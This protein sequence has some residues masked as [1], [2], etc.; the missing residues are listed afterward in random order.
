MK[1]K[2][3]LE[4][5]SLN[6][7]ST[8][9]EAVKLTGVFTNTGEVGVNGTPR[10]DISKDGKL[11]ATANSDPLLVLPRQTAN[12]VAYFAPASAG[13]YDID[14]HVAYANKQ[15][16]DKATILNVQDSGTNT[17]LLAGIIVAIAA[18]VAIGV[19]YY[20]KRA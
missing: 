11:V 16:E 3:E 7:W 1:S 9:G 19:Y 13:Q 8:V 12:L 20:Q 18:V 14:G 5:I 17:L 10:L 4:R 6:P 15:T 2:G